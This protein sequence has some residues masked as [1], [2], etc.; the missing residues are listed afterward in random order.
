[1]CLLFLR[2]IALA[3]IILALTQPESRIERSD[4]NV[5][6]IDI[7][8][9]QDISGSMMSEDFKPNR[10]EAAKQVAMDFIDGRANDRIGLVV[11]SAESFLQCPLTIDHGQAKESFK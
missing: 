10:I 3:C 1:M 2:M 9:A 5:E 4:Y 6:G 11:F 8:L 7:I